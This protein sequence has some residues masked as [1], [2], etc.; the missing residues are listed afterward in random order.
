MKKTALMVIVISVSLLF[1]SGTVPSQEDVQKR[2]CC[3]HHGGVCGCDPVSGMQKCCDG[4]L[5]PSCEC[6]E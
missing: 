2:G 3:S 4:T 1:F 6:G 5:S